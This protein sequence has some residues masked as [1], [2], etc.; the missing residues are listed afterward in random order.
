MSDL[1]GDV[2]RSTDA[3][4]KEGAP[5]HAWVSEIGYPTHIQSNGVDGCT[6]ARL[7]VRTLAI[8]QASLKIDKLFWYDF[9][10][11]GLDLAY[12]E[13]NFGVVHHQ[14]LNCAPKPSVVA[15]SVFARITAGAK[16][17]SIWH[18]DSL[19]IAKYRGANGGDLQVVWTTGASRPLSVKG[20]KLKAFDIM[21]NPVTVSDA[22]AATEDALYLTGQRIAVTPR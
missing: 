3:A 10:N 7:G 6:Q 11:D 16:P 5:K 12:N 9:K 18:D 17:L 15:F 2:T 19:W 14:D 13:C 8:L 4:L 22:A 1:I 21:G 20:A